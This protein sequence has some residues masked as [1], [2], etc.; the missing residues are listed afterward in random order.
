VA[1]TKIVFLKLDI[2]N[3]RGSSDEGITHQRTGHDEAARIGRSVSETGRFSWK[4][5]I[6]RNKIGR[7]DK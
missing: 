1:K 6:N 7:E 3:V 4:G 2:F 5:E